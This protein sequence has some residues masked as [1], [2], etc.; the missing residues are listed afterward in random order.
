M[1]ER[2]KKRLKLVVKYK[3]KR[4]ALKNVIKKAESYDDVMKAQAEL[5]SLP[6]NSSQVRYQT[7][8]MQCGRPHAVYRKFELCRLCLRLY[9]MSGDVTGGRKSSW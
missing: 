9:L 5:M 2:E 4:L 3:E 6:V 1:V 8:C 7:R